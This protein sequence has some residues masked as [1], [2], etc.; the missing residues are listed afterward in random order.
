MNHRFPNNQCP[1]IYDCCPCCTFGVVLAVCL[2]SCSLPSLRDC[3]HN[4]V[5]NEIVKLTN[6]QENEN[7][8]GHGTE[9]LV[10]VVKFSVYVW[11]GQLCVYCL[12]SLQH[13]LTCN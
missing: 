11:V 3:F 5:I 6:E 7:S 10:V 8:S 9:P 1:T 13:C 12:R 4:C 2:V